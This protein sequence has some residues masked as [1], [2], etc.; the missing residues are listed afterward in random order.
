MT[1]PTVSGWGGLFSL[2]AFRII[3]N[4]PKLQFSDFYVLTN[5]CLRAL[6]PSLPPSLPHTVFQ[7]Y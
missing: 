1:L 6:P 7:L 4:N 5:L 3:L 2:H